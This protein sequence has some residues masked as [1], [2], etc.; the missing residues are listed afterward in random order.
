MNKRKD[1]RSILEYVRTVDHN[2][3]NARADTNFF[4][5]EFIVGEFHEARLPYSA[6]PLGSR[7][8]VHVQ[9]FRDPSNDTVIMRIRSFR[10]VSYETPLQWYAGSII[11]PRGAQR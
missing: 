8:A 4:L 6:P 7:F 10:V 2:F 1:N 11:M 9:A 3:F 5:R